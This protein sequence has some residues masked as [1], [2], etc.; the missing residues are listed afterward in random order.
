[1]CDSPSKNHTSDFAWLMTYKSML[2]TAQIFSNDKVMFPLLMLQISTQ[3]AFSNKSYKALKWQIW[4]CELGYV[5][6]NFTMCI[7]TYT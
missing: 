4:K 3:Y 2:H 7:R 5:V 6:I 1:M